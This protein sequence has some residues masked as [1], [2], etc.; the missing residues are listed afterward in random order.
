MSDPDVD[1]ECVICMDNTV[2]KY[3]SC[4]ICKNSVCEVCIVRI[5]NE[6]VI[7]DN[8]AS[9]IFVCP[10]CSGNSVN[11]CENMNNLYSHLY[12]NIKD[13]DKRTNRLLKSKEIEIQRIMDNK[14]AV[15]I[16]EKNLKIK[17]LQSEIDSQKLLNTHLTSS[18]NELKTALADDKMHQLRIKL[19]KFEKENDCLK[20]NNKLLA[21]SI[22]Q[23]ISI[24]N[25]LLH[26][27][28]NDGAATCRDEITCSNDN[29]VEKIINFDKIKE[30][31]TK[32]ISNKRKFVNIH[33]LIAFF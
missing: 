13:T 20:N 30:Y 31:I 21:D 26:K 29:L 14:Y 10:F 5:T 27:K 1:T 33:D 32:L 28:T 18:I 17:R 2:S 19:Q 22:K 8:K 9:I 24:N 23:H 12:N 7:V 25:Q 4:A 3:N 15:H 11:S 6:Y 16:T